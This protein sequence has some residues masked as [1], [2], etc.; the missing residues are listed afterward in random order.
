MKKSQIFILV[1]IAILALIAIAYAFGFLYPLNNFFKNQTP[2]KS[3][4]FDSDCGYFILPEGNVYCFNIKD[5]RMLEFNDSRVI[6]I[7]RDWKPFCPFPKSMS[8]AEIQCIG[9]MELP[10]DYDK[11]IRCIDNVCEK[12]LS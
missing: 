8:L 6:A 11:K 1:L 5:C 12:V 9:G 3:C 2:D 10:P 7:K 4:I